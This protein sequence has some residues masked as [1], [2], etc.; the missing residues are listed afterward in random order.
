MC[1]VHVLLFEQIKKER[2]ERVVKRRPTCGSYWWYWPVRYPEEYLYT[3]VV[4]S[5]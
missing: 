1:V 3:S 4:V 5:D 2:K